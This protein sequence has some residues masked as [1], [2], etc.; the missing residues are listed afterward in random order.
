MV[1]SSIC[2]FVVAFVRTVYLF[3]LERL[4]R[5]FIGLWHALCLTTNY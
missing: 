3:L 2:N 4:V 5:F 1:L